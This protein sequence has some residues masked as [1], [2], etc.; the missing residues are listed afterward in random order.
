MSEELIAIVFGHFIGDFFLQ[1]RAMADN[2]F[3]E[4]Y[5]ASAWC[6]L[7]VVV[8]TTTVAIFASNFTVIFVL[9][10]ALPHWIIDRFSLAHTWMRI[11][12]R[13]D[14]LPNSDPTKAAFG[15]V[16]YVV[17]DQTF[18][19]GSLYILILLIQN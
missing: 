3:R 12:G 13:G 5:R 15:A 11:I 14:L 8:Y 4:G 1:H 16:I 17:I 18:H 7:H 9:G 19:L 2:K 6:S 10:V